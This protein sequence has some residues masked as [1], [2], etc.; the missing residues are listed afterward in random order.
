MIGVL[1]IESS[2]SCKAYLLP[3]VDTLSKQVTNLVVCTGDG[4]AHLVLPLNAERR[5]LPMEV[6]FNPVALIYRIVAW[7]AYFRTLKPHFLYVHQTRSSLI[8]LFCAWVNRTPVRIYHNHGLPFIGYTGMLRF[9]LLMLER[10]N[11]MFATHILFV[12]KSNLVSALESKM[13]G[14]KKAKLASIWADGSISGIAISDWKAA[15]N[16]QTFANRKLKSVEPIRFGYVGRPTKRKG[17]HFLLDLWALGDFGS[18]CHLIIAGC[19]PL[20]I[21]KAGR[22]ELKNVEALGYVED[23]S[24]FYSEIDVLLFPSQHEGLGYVILE[25][26]T[27]CKTSICSD[28]PGIRCAVLD[29]TSG[30]LAKHDSKEEWIH[31]MHQLEHNLEKRQSAGEKAFKFVQEKFERGRVLTEAKKYFS[32][33]LYGEDFK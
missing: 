19:S 3:I 17:F 32:R 33:V 25:A 30:F 31:I 1:A 21:V 13:L 7:Y 10:F 29:N 23:M 12:S 20:D 16:S 6:T 5:V 15:V 4:K 2:K 9:M 24:K 18:R 8:P 22:A 14:K 11:G 26:A 27:F 28:I